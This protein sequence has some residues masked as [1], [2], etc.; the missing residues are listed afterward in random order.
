[1]N[2]ALFLTSLGGIAGLLLFSWWGPHMV[3]WWFQPPV[4][5]G[6]DCRQA[7]DWSMGKLLLIQM[8]GTIL[9]FSAGIAMSIAISRRG[10]KLVNP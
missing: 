3:G 8:I 5:I 10:K 4:N 1:M 7:I 6:I 2:R 9:G